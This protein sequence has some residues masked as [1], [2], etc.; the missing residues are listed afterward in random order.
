MIEL[1]CLDLRNNPY[2][3]NAIYNDGSLLLFSY[4]ILVPDGC[5][6]LHTCKPSFY[7]LS[8][9]EKIFY[10]EERALGRP[11]SGLSVS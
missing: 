5:V 4:L 9:L 10:G 7:P 6:N 3:W 2:T 1:A 8:Y 11:D